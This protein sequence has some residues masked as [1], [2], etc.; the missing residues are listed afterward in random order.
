MRTVFLTGLDDDLRAD[1]GG[2]VGL[3][4][5]VIEKGV[6]VDYLIYKWT[7]DGNEIKPF[8]KAHCVDARIL[9]KIADEN[10]YEIKAYDW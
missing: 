3:I 6:A 8:L 5:D 9:E 4:A 7:A 1:L 2:D 10:R